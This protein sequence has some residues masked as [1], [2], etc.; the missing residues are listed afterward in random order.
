MAW[1]SNARYTNHMTSIAFY[2]WYWAVIAICVVSHFF[3]GLFSI[4]SVNFYKTNRKL[5]RL[6]I[7]I[8]AK[9]MKMKVVVHG[10]ENIPA[11]KPCIFMANHSSLIDILVMTIAVPVHFNFMA[12]KELFW[13]PFIGLQ[14]VFGGDFLIDRNNPKKAKACLKKVEK[15]LKKGWNMLIFPE[16]T[17]SVNGDLLPFKGGGFKLAAITGAHIVP[18][19]I[20]GSDTIVRKKSMK[21]TPGQVDIYFDRPVVHSKNEA[22]RDD[23]S[24]L[25]DQTKQQIQ[26]LLTEHRSSV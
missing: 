12:K 11:N 8:I 3:L 7:I 19:Y 18:C 26:R 17:R 1:Y 21:A 16:G 4:F 24:L 23:I 9:A 22:S 25:M 5:A 2:A 13:V 20:R 15:R 6:F 10:I 14:M